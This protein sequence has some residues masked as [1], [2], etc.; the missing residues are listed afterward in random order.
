MSSRAIIHVTGPVRSGKTAF[1]EA[2]LLSSRWLWTLAARCTM[3]S[4]LERP[5]ES[6][7]ARHERRERPEAD[8]RCRGRSQTRHRYRE[9]ERSER[10]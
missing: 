2:V 9:R 8:I 10:S 4:T 5:V 6:S 1:V 3:D 7:L